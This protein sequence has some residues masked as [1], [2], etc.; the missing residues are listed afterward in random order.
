MGEALRS[1]DG[2]EFLGE[3]LEGERLVAGLR[4]ALRSEHHDAAGSVGHP[5]GG[6]GLVAVLPAGAAGAGEL[7]VT[8]T[9]QGLAFSVGRLLAP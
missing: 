3:S 2:R 5:Y 8:F 6:F 7:D 9:C 1:F 4:A